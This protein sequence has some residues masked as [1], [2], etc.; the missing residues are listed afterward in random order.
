M[1]MYKKQKKILIKVIK[2]VYQLV[3]IEK[4]EK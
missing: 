3:P 2:Q 1:M 4:I